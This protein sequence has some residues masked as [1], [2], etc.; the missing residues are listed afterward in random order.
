MMNDPHWGFIL[1]AYFL[2]IWVLSGLLYWIVTDYRLQNKALA[3]LEAAGAKRR[4]D[5]DLE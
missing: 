1:T 3:A 4:S 2:G 5:G